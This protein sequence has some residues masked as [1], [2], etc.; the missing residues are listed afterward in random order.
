MWGSL[1]GAGIAAYGALKGRQKQQQADSY[2]R[3]QLA[4]EQQRYDAAAPLRNQGMRGLGQVE[5]AMDLGNYAYDTQNPFAVARGKPPSTA[6]YGGWDKMT[7]D[8]PLETPATQDLAKQQAFLDTA[9]QN[10]RGNKAAAKV[11]PRIQ[12]EIDRRRAAL[13]ANQQQGAT[14]YGWSR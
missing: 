5:G 7:F 1:I 4:Q 11:L 14:S 3:E 10:M 2:N 12:A 6:T 8:A 13:P 9:T